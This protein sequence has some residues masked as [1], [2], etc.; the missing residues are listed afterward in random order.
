MGQPLRKKEFLNFFLS[1]CGF[2]NYY[3]IKIKYYELTKE[4]E[5]A[6]VEDEADEGQDNHLPHRRVELLLLK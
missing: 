1:F 4:Y 5:A 2:P 6:D 3:F